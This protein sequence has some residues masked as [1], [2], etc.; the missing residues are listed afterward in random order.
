MKIVD[1]YLN[2][3]KK[4][5]T[6]DDE[7]LEKIKEKASKVIHDTKD[8]IDDIRDS[9]EYKDLKKDTFYIYA[10]TKKTV[11]DFSRS[12][13]YEKFKDD[14]VF[15]VE[16][17]EEKSKEF[18]ESLNHKYGKLTNDNWYYNAAETCEE[19]SDAIQR[20][21]SGTSQKIVNGVV[22]KAGAVGTSAGIFSIAAAL[23]TA[24][25]GTAI[26]SLSGA[27]FTSSALA[28]LGGSVVIGGAIITVASIAGGVGAVY[29]IKHLSR[30]YLYGEKRDKDKDL[31][32][33]EQK[34][35]ESCISLSCAFRKLDEEKKE[36][37]Y[38]SAKALYQ[39]A[40]R[41]I[42]DELK[43]LEV[44]TYGW[45]KLARKNLLDSIEKLKHIILFLND[46]IISNPIKIGIVSAVTMQLLSNEID[47]FNDEEELVLDALRRSNN[48]LTDASNAELSEYI[49][50]LEP[51]QI[52][53][54]HSNIKGI[55][56]ELKYQDIENSDDD[57]YRVELFDETNH[58]GADIKLINELTG[59][60]KEFQ[61]KATDS[62]S[63]INKHNERYEDIEV[64]ATS[65]VASRSDEIL[66]SGISVEE[67]NET[68][69]ETF[70]QLDNNSAVSSSMSIAAVVSLA[71][72]INILLKEKEIS[73]EEKSKLLQDGVVAAGIAGITSLIFF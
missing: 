28:W 45:E 11:V 46:Y 21:P 26:G 3:V 8:K 15:L 56:H 17:S 27:A 64:I 1:R 19:I 66:D 14:V 39:D 23:G 16:K 37:D 31:S 40:L 38:I 6:I 33:M 51:N 58:A 63:Y 69:S 20:E 44:Q 65:E 25:T 32:L 22:G 24:S 4:S 72:N 54:L 12:N 13:E 60:I 67:I 73:A 47:L 71:K 50:A 70:N 57:I 49:Q 30:K 59:E 5:L 2:K 62:L 48:D 43:E 42:Y 18:Y 9:N 7:Q 41:P 55:Y 34:V 68:V 36:L 61:L 53:G 10:K 52:Q 35:V 29:G